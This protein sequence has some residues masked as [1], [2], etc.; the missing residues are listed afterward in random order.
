MISFPGLGRFR[1]AAKRLRAGWLARFGPAEL[2]IL[3][4]FVPPPYGGGNQFLLALRG[5]LER[6]GHEVGVNYVGPRTR[7]VLV[8]STQVD[9]AALDH[10]LRPGVRVVHRID[11]PI[12]V[13]RGSD[14]PTVDREVAA[15]N[16]RIAHATIMQSQYSLA[17][18]RRLGIELVAPAVIPNAPDPAIFHPP[19]SP[20]PRG[21]KLRVIAT[22][23]SD[24]PQ[25]GAAVYRWLDEHLDTGR[26]EF[27]FVGRVGATLSRARQLPPMPSGPLADELRAHDV[28]L[29][30]TRNDA[31]SNALIE[32]LACGLPAVF[33][34]SGGSPELVGEGGLGFSREDE[35]PA[36]L[37]R[38]SG[39]LDE[40]RARIRVVPLADVAR[41]YLDV[42][43][44]R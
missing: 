7:A 41:R 36:L 8:N 30:A 42:M 25:K 37:A 4:D 18:H 10:M 39:E 34:R 44:G 12:S 3:F 1:R 23:W 16:H 38:M 20:R 15:L 27:T 14:D 11:G 24:N 9:L 31:C 29:T 33:A 17:E 21:A 6:Q 28:Y 26:F 43:L 32:A 19:A 40:F 22:A 2:A 13:Y 35:I 5:E